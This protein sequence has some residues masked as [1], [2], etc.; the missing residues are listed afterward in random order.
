ERRRR[1]LLHVLR[2]VCE[3]RT[4]FGPLSD[5]DRIVTSLYGLDVEGALRRGDWYQTEEVLLRGR[6]GAGFPTAMKWSFMNK[7]SDGRSLFGLSRT[8]K[9]SFL[10]LYC[11]S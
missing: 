11:C 3:R 7:P 2:T 6:G 9:G 1:H 4:T 5:R 10:V 8:P